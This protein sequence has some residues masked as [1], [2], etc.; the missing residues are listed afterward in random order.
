M[1]SDSRFSEKITLKA[2][3]RFYLLLFFRRFRSSRRRRRFCVRQWGARG[4][5]APVQNDVVV[6]HI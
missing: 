1:S 5:V 2:R 4:V 3:V 6:V